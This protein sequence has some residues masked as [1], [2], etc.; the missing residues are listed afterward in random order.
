ML[1][2]TPEATARLHG[3]IAA[4]IPA[5]VVT[6]IFREQQI[7][8]VRIRNRRSG[9]VYD[10]GLNQDSDQMLSY[11]AAGVSWHPGPAD[12]VE[13]READMTRTVMRVVA[14][15]PDIAGGTR[16]VELQREGKV[17]A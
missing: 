9:A 10:P 3:Q 8:A 11:V 6:L 16:V 7:P 12:R 1:T 2:I 5:A 14:T 13:I 17:T 4:A 15:R